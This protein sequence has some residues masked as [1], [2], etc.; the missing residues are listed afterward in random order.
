MV[1][2]AH[3]VW[4]GG[5]YS[6][7]GTVTT[8]GG[9]LNNSSYV[10]GL[11][12]T[13]ASTTPGELLAAAV[14]SS[15]SAMV[16]LKMAQLG[17]RLSAVDTRAVVAMDDSGDGWRFSGIRLEITAQMLE[18]ATDRLFYEAVAEARRE[19]PVVSVLNLD[20]A[21]TA[22]LVPLDAPIAA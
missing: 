6:G 21:C 7:K 11:A 15:M 4:R 19:C 16:S 17:A 5:P 1:R 13:T 9:I 20:V 12:E 8:P 3:A 22:K 14:A 2:E 18:P 10:F